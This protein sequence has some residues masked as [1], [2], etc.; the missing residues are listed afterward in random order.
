MFLPKLGWVSLLLSAA[1]GM[2]LVL[3]GAAQL[4][5][6]PCS[7]VHHTHQFVQG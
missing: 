5:R 4:H 7:S 6:I 1:T 3:L 2:G